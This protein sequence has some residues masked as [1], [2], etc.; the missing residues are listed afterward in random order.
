MPDAEKAFAK[1]VVV[2]QC[3]RIKYMAGQMP[4][5][6]VPM[7]DA[8]LRL[9]PGNSNACPCSCAIPSLGARR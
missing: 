5:N 3:Y 1:L 8:V 7:G 6:Y 9:N 2:G 4:A